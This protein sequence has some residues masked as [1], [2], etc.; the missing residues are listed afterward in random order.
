[1]SGGKPRL[2]FISP[3]FLFP[4]D[5]GG[6]T[7]T[8]SILRGLAGGAFDVTLISP[9]TAHQRSAWEP[10][11]RQISNRFVAWQ[12]PAARA[13]WMRA[14]DLL[15]ELPVN[16]AADR[17]T[18]ALSAVRRML[19]AD[20]FDVIV[21]DFVHAA[22]LRPRQVNA[23]TVC[24]THNVEAE[25]F[26]RHARQ[27]RNPLMRFA[28]A[29]QYEKMQR[30]E[31]RALALFDCVVAVSERDAA[32]FRERY[33][34]AVTQT[35]PTG[36][37]LGFFTWQEPRDIDPK[38]PTVVFIGSMD[39]AANID[40]VGHFLAEVWPLVLR[41][42]PQAR[43]V[44]VGR[45]PPASLIERSRALSNVHFSGY[46]DDVRPCVHAAQVFVIPLRVGSGTRI[47]AFES[48]A[49]GCPVISTSVGI[50]GLDV[51]AGE[52]Y[53]CCNA[54][55]DQAR[56]IVDLLLNPALRRQLSR[57]ARHCVEQK[58]GH[59]VAARAFEQHCLGAL[60]RFRSSHPVHG[61]R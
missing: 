6:K 46:V 23:A 3:I 61:A 25:I 51:V 30:F 26:A 22:V 7:R 35:I 38:Q 2:A 36:V 50:E 17:T 13:S 41:E 12:P 28:W 32:H 59:L 56:A 10:Q 8:T 34:V 47:K 37:D 14:L 16:V 11:L 33:G 27:A 1:M 42:L 60:E 21:F 55:E 31:R 48:M 44:V 45:Q 19:A 58:F 53:L 39:W 18:P 52:H 57:R 29:R 5:A 24:F 20:G 4:N 9:A 54:A 43:F 49:M 40:G 15:G